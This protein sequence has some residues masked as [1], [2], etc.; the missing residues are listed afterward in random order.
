[1][2]LIYTILTAI[3]L[4]ASLLYAY[5]RGVM[6]GVRLSEG[7]PIEPVRSPVAVVQEYVEEKKVKVEQDK[8]N[9]GMAN[10]FSYDPQKAQGGE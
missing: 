8:F 2:E 10:I 9:Q 3:A 7:K 5:R 4:S 1:M 6:D